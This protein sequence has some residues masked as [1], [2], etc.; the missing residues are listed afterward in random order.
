VLRASP[1][2]ICATPTGDNGGDRSRRRLT[3][4]R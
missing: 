2:R 1:R 3:A 4:P